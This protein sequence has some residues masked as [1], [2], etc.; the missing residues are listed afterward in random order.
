MLSMEHI[1]KAKL[2]CRNVDEHR[3]VLEPPTCVNQIA[4]LQEHR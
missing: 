3:H 4:M 1:A 2:I